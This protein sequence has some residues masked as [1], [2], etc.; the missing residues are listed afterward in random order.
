MTLPRRLQHPRALVAFSIAGAT[1]IVVVV[2]LGILHERGVVGRQFDLDAEFEIPAYA[3]S[4]LLV[5]AA[6][7]C[8]AS[9]TTPAR[10]ALQRVL[11][12]HGRR[13]AVELPRA[14]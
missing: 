14:T 5:A 9:G 13:R 6:V 1:V 12:V 7:L 4:L 10:I 11:P 8:W 2:A 3:S